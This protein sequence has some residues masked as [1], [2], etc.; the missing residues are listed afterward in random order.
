MSRM[1]PGMPDAAR[2]E[3]QETNL[4]VLRSQIER[5]RH[6]LFFWSRRRREL[7]A[8]AEEEIPG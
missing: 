2:R 7:E 3:A 4:P 8:R 6:R 1:I 5:F